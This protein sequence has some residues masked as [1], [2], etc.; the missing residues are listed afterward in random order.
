MN[1]F[2]DDLLDEKTANNWI[3]QNS[4]EW[5]RIRIGRFTASELHRL[6]DPAKREMTKE[7]LEARPKSGKGSSSKLI[8]DY[9]RLS[10]EAMSYIEEKVAE[11]LTDTP[12]QQ[13]YAFPITWGM[14][15]EDEAIEFF[16]KRTGMVVQRVGFFSYSTHAGGS[17]DGLVGDTAIIEAKCPFNSVI[18]LKYLM[19]TDQ[20][21]VKRNYW[22]YWVQCQANMLFTGRELSYFT[23]YD[24][25]MVNDKHKIQIIEIKADS[26]FHDLI[27]KQIEL[28]TKEKLSLLQT[29][30]P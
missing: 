20:W 4:P 28:A 5:D 12:K 11:I 8:Y 29:L 21:D 1:S 10:D 23:T 13:G 18:Q 6:M 3:S 7:E 15:H 26:E 24:P 19:L 9:S 22:S 17:P 14:E 16:E 25:R 30:Q 27:I 2:L